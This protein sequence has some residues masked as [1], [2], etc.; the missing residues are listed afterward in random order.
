MT[1]TLLAAFHLADQLNLSPPPQFAASPFDT[2]SQT[3]VVARNPDGSV[4]GYRW[5]REQ[6]NLNEKITLTNGPSN[7]SFGYIAMNMDGRFYGTM[8]D[9][10]HEYRW[11]AGDPYTFIY[12][13]PV[14]ILN[15]TSS[16]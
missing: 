15:G 6:W 10:I 2:W 9:T 3:L 13:G 16:R 5:D 4:T 11:Y 8:N 7:P 14:G 12:I 1:P